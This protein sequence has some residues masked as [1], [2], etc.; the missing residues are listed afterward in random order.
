[1]LLRC[2]LEELAWTAQ[3]GADSRPGRDFTREHNENG[4]L[5][6]DRGRCGGFP[7]LILRRD[8]SAIDP[9]S[10]GPTAMPLSDYISAA[11]FGPR[12][13]SLFLGVLGHFHAARR[14]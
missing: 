12:L 4:P 8:M 10:A 1:M 3:R 5:C 9:N 11:W 13:A 6:P 2:I 7:P 14:L